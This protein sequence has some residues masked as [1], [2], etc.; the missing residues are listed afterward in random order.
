MTIGAKDRI[1]ETAFTMSRHVEQ[2]KLQIS[3]G[4]VMY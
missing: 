1:Y 2:S 4:K 3:S